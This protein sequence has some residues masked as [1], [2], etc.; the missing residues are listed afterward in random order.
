[1]SAIEFETQLWSEPALLKS[2]KIDHQLS[3]QAVY[4]TENNQFKNSY[5]SSR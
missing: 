1:M 4:L 2:V 3:Q 5:T